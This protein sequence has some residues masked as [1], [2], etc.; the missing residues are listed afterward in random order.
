MNDDVSAATTSP[1]P[2]LA[3][4]TSALNEIM[5]TEEGR[6]L[7]GNL[8]EKMEALQKKFETLSA[9][10]KE[11]YQREFGAKFEKAIHNLKGVIQEKV[12][13]AVQRRIVGTGAL[14]VI[15]IIA[16]VVFGSRHQFNLSQLMFLVVDLLTGQ[17]RITDDIIEL[18]LS[19]SPL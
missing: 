5:R 6:Q 3:S 15:V 13:E 19:V 2:D 16:L 7:A 4:A 1:A 14:I 17:F 11:R 12:H 8:Q 10:D 9:E 18:S